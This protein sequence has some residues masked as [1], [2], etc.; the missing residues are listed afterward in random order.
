[1]PIFTSSFGF[2]ASASIATTMSTSATTNDSESTFPPIDPKSTLERIPRPAL[3]NTKLCV[4]VHVPLKDKINKFKSGRQCRTA[5][6]DASLFSPSQNDDHGCHRFDD[7]KG[8]EKHVDAPITP[9]DVLPR[10]FLFDPTPMTSQPPAPSRKAKIYDFISRSTSRSRSKSTRR[11]S[12]SSVLPESD[13]TTVTVTTVATDPDTNLDSNLTPTRH[14]RSKPTTRSPSRPLSS[15]TSGTASTIT[16]L[17]APTRARTP[18]AYPPPTTS[19]HPIY[20]NDMADR[21]DYDP[22]MPPPPVPQHKRKS[23]PPTLFGFPLPTLSRPTTPKDDR[24]EMVSPPVTP[25][26]GRSGWDPRRRRSKDRSSM[27]RARGSGP[28]A[29]AAI[30][31]PKPRSAPAAHAFVTHHINDGP[32]DPVLRSMTS[33]PDE[34]GVHALS[35]SRPPSSHSSR[36]RCS[37][38]FNLRFLTRSRSRGES[39]RSTSRKGKGRVPDEDRPRVSVPVISTRTHSRDNGPPSAGLVPNGV[40]VRSARHGSFDF[41]RIHSGTQPG[42]AGVGSG[43]GPQ[44]LHP[45]LTEIKRSV[46]SGGADRRMRTSNHGYTHPSA[47]PGHGYSQSTSA[48]AHLR[49]RQDVGP[50]NSPPSAHSHSTATTGTGV[51]GAD[52]RLPAALPQGD[53]SWGRRT[54]TAAWARAGV[55]PPFAFESATSGSAVS[56]GRASPAGISDRGKGSL[57][58]RKN[59]RR[60]DS[61]PRSGLSQ[62]HEREVDL[63]LGL[64]W[65]PSKIRVRE[66]T[67]L[68]ERAGSV[69]RERERKDR[70]RERERTKLLLEGE[71]RHMQEMGYADLRRKNDKQVTARYK[72]VLGEQGF[73]TFKKCE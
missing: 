7:I 20:P 17:N 25:A 70:E 16:P 12:K 45:G 42:L 60:D 24:L 50:Q 26:R 41:E 65:A 2:L 13:L 48:R 68:R 55:H 53:G 62:W 52:R 67:G 18:R 46:S 5:I 63:G 10:T 57:D 6:V 56:N 69:E 33:P 27:E 51:T 15:N 58:S 44:G 38:M 59:A 72:A 29:P 39:S 61:Q 9:I 32:A 37:P 35:Y 14:D 21:Q 22:S 1:M 3:S 23:K 64:A 8:D 54:R 19:G 49:A 66:F 73:E 30:H 28:S 4:H 36:G 40:N 71:K 43:G 34:A 11:S 31:A 47:Q